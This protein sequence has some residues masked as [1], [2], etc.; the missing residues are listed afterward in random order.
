MKKYLWMI[1]ILII[2]VL[3][4]SIIVVR[5]GNEPAP[6]G[7]ERDEHGC[8]GPAG[9]SWNETLG[10][11]LREWE[12]NENARE[13]VKIAAD[14][15]GRN[16]SLTVVE[17]IFAKCPGCFIVR[18][19]KLKDR[20]DVTLDNWIV[21]K[22]S[23]TPEEC[24]KRNGRTLNIVAG[25]TCNESEINIGD[26]TGFISP[27]ICC[28][29]KNYCTEE[30]RGPGLYCIQVY[31]PVCGFPMKETFSNSCVACLN[32]SVLYY[33]EGECQ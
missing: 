25:D 21:I 14:Y 6:I 7:G 18:F 28:V 12:I 11:C 27:N 4:A 19:E 32:E 29:L 2:I 20:I 26:V 15:I 30:Q 9:Y 8:L 16:Y 24:T 10:V 17:V 22:K 23:L 31:E 33:V 3:I 5:N 1:I 13:A